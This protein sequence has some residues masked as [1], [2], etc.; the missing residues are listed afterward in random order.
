MKLQ[1]VQFFVDKIIQVY[2]SLINE[3][4]YFFFFIKIYEMMLVRHGFMIVGPF[5]GGKSS[6]YKILAGA[7][8]DLEAAGMMDEHKVVYKVINPKSITIG[9]LYGE[10]DSKINTK[11]QI[12]FIDFIFFFYRGFT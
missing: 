7:L 2:F 5:M 1:P 8:A 11:N 10:F 3:E 12:E 4:K 9:Q 6:A